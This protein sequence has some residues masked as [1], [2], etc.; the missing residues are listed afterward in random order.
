MSLRK[1]DDFVV[2]ISFGQEPIEMFMTHVVVLTSGHR[3]WCVNVFIGLVYRLPLFGS[4]GNLYGFSLYSITYFTGMGQFI[5]HFEIVPMSLELCTSIASTFTRNA[6]TY[7]YMH[8]TPKAVR[9]QKVVHAY[10][11][12]FVSL[13]ARRRCSAAF[14]LAVDLH[15]SDSRGYKVSKL[16]LRM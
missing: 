4:I 6:L 14:R 9:T 7:K 13:G 8:V 2:R 15:T 16:Y 1:W 5:F 10:L 11:S 3:L 12:F